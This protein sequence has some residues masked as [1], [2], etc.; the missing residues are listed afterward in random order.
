MKLDKI[1]EDKKK[2]PDLPLTTSTDQGSNGKWRA[3]FIGDRHEIELVGREREKKDILRKVLQKDGDHECSF[4]TVV[5]LDGIGKTA[6]AKYVYSVKVS[7]IFDVKAWVHVSTNFDLKKI[8]A[9]VISQVEDTVIADDATLQFLK[10]HLDRIL[11]EK[12]YLIVLDDL[13]EEGRYNLEALMNMLQSGKKGSKIIVTTR[14]EKVAHTLCTIYS[15]HFH[16]VQPIRFEGLSTDE[17]W[18]I[19]KPYNRGIGGELTELVDLGKEIV[20]KCSGVPLVA[21]ALGHV[22]NKYCTSKEWLEIKI[23]TF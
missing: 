14:S 3:T 7:N 2:L 17:C 9:N 15:S 4:I 1:A 11:C 20:E 12:L 6:I 8:A 5:G 10:S 18:S 13:W 21:K 19:M 22:M 23:V 16:T